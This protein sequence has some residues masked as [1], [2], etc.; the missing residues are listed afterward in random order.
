MTL[1]ADRPAP[2]PTLV[3]EAEIVYRKRPIAA[4]EL[5]AVELKIGCS[6]D[7]ANILRPW[8][9]VSVAEQFVVLALSARNQVQSTHVA[10]K[11]NS[12]FCPVDV[13]SVLRFAILSGAPGFIVAHNHPSGDVRASADDVALTERLRTAFEAI[14]LTLLDHVIVTDGAE[15]YSFLDSGL[16]GARS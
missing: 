9:G 8:I 3:R 2:R 15:H 10:G 5:G 16:L 1:S 4:D 6:R 14:G 12:S 13:T 7:A 11:G